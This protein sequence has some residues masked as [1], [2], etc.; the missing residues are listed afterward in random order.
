MLL[1]VLRKMAANRWMVASLLV[2]VILAVA[3]VTTIPIYSRG[4]LTRLLLRD[5]QIHQER[6]LGYPGS[7][8]I[9]GYLTVDPEDEERLAW[10][11]E[12][13]GLI[14]RDV[15]RGLVV[16]IQS[17]AYRLQQN[18]LRLQRPG[19]EEENRVSTSVAGTTGLLDQVRPI[20]GTLP[21]RAADDRATV[22]E[23]VITQETAAAGRIAYG[24]TY[25]IYAPRETLPLAFEVRIVGV[26]EMIDPADVYWTHSLRR[27]E[28]VVIMD[29]EDVRRVIVTNNPA[30]N[31][32]AYW[33]YAFDYQLLNSED[34]APMAAFVKEA[35]RL[36][37]Q[38]GVT[39][40][41]PVQ[42]ILEEY[43]QREL[44]LNMTLW[45]LQVP[46]LLMLAFYLF[47]VS[48]IL[49]EH[50][51]N[52]IALMKSRGARVG[53]VFLVY[54][55][56][57]TLLSLAGVLVGPF[58]G[59]AICRVLGASSGFLE[60]VQRRTLRLEI[61]GR[62]YLYGIVA[63]TVALATMLVP[64]L[65]A[66]RTT[67]VHHKQR[68]SRGAGTPLWRKLFLDV[69][70]LGVA[71]YGLYRYGERSTIVALSGLDAT[72]ISMDPVLLVM[73]TLFVIGLG[74]LFLRVYPFVIRLLYRVGA[75]RWPPVVF[76]SLVQ[77]GR[78]SG[79]HQFLMLF[80][81][82][83]ISIGIYNADAARTLNQNVEERLWYNAGADVVLQ[84]EWQQVTASGELVSS[85]SAG[86]P[87]MMGG[88]AESASGTARYIEPS[89]RRIR[90]LPGV[91]LATPVF[92]QGRASGS[93]L[94]GDSFGQVS[95]F[96]IIPQDFGRTAWFRND[97][98]AHHWYHYL[99]LLSQSPAAALVSSS[100]ADQAGLSLGDPI[101]LRWEDQPSTLY[102]VYGIVDYWPGYNPHQAR[103]STGERH[104][105]V[106]NLHYLQATTALEPYEVWIDLDDSITS[107]GFYAGVEASGVKL[108]RLIDTRQN[109][110]R[111]RNDPILQG[112][113]GTLSLGFLV[114]LGVCFVGFL[115][116]WTF[117]IRERTLQFGLFRAM[118]LGKLAIV[119][120]LG[121]EQL[122]IS[123]AAVAA[124]FGIG[125]LT[126]ILFVPLLQV[127]RSARETVPPF[128]VI[129]LLTDQ[130]RIAGFVT[131]MLLFGFVVLSAFLSRI[132]IHQA[133]KLG[134]E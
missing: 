115:L 26:V 70:L 25:E 94:G 133:V 112:T 116:Y 11:D 27:Y 41:L 54:V 120:M 103:H 48:Q 119:V 58:V 80:L 127:V 76:A 83:S 109:L 69:I 5:L 117:S 121:L 38:L 37:R 32:E 95:L 44:I 130:L 2:G 93:L 46:L 15:R 114:S 39:V 74:L 43:T 97:L 100:L 124:G 67:I 126:S 99:N 90:E 125:R 71:V 91:R 102:Y 35:T 98:L 8:E 111:E 49:I 50:E 19:D 30:R 57:G 53:Q 110:I 134:E 64:A 52:E 47:M 61:T 1:F 21:Q 86:D 73:S 123:G 23:A 85:E 17:H 16:P 82:L 56:L 84:Q 42:R 106:V 104:L 75:R 12:L 92:Y 72:E 36:G 113:N 60:F 118:G 55:V 45:V 131:L 4:I 9:S 81:I 96:G 107:A 24:Q 40:R 28:G 105:A 29:P 22:I 132:R 10:Y 14:D 79:K 122:F 108:T 78:G 34:A 128:R 63:A 66:S 33:I 6:T 101:Y 65:S 129:S 62:T 59:L 88:A 87:S 77:V 18:F 51:R 68:L 3:M 89:F 20:V 7:L 31:L 13:T